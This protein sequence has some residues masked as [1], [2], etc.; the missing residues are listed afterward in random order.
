MIYEII[1]DKWSW[2]MIDIER[3]FA[4]DNGGDEYTPTVKSS[5]SYWVNTKISTK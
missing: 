4:S 3:I 5:G 1:R 2:E